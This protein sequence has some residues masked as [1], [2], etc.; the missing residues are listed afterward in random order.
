MHTYSVK[1]SGQLNFHTGHMILAHVYLDSVLL[2]TNCHL[3]KAPW[4]FG[5]TE[6]RLVTIVN[7]GIKQLNVQNM[8]PLSCPAIHWLAHFFW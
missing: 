4:S 3:K 7:A 2:G 8:Q 1:W 5:R 6:K